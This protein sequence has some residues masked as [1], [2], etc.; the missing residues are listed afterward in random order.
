MGQ[1]GVMTDDLN[2]FANLDV[3]VPGAADGPLSGMTFAAK[4]IFDVAGHV[5]GGGNPDWQR[6]HGPA[7]RTAPAVQAA[8]RR[9]RDARRQ[10][11]HRRANSRHPGPEPALRYARE[12]R[13]PRA[14]FRADRPAGRRRRLRAA[15]STSRS[16][17]TPGAPCGCHP[18]SAVCTAYARPMAAYPS[19]ACSLRRRASTPS[20][21]SPATP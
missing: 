16:A 1:H 9:R 10:D 5:T 13:R 12:P 2:A 21:G 8:A 15:L 7:E 17:P 18:A 14:E 20:D 11:P 4:D 3:H 19:T 6:T